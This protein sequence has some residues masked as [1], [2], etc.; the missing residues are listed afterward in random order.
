MKKQPRHTVV[1]LLLSSYIILGAI[2]PFETLYAL[3]SGAKPHSIVQAKSNI[4]PTTKVFWT[5]HKHIPSAVKISVPSPAVQTPVEADKPVFFSRLFL[6]E[7]KSHYLNSDFHF[8][9][10]RAPPAL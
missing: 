7:I 1:Y 2:G 10:L 5:Q 4:P 9:S 6:H 8:I 3:C